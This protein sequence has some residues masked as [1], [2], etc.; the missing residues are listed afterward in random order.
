MKLQIEDL[1]VVPEEAP[2]TDAEQ[3]LEAMIRS[4]TGPAQTKGLVNNLNSLVKKK[5]PAAPPPVIAANGSESGSGS[6]SVEESAAAGKRKA[7]E[8]QG[9]GEEKKAKLEEV[10]LAS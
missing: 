7:E 5:K 10:K 9:Q 4:A 1:K 6:T 8:A 3:A 2:K